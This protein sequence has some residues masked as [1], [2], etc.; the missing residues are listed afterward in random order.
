MATVRVGVGGW[1][2]APWR[3]NFYPAGLPHS[4]ELHH[5]S[6]RLT[7][8]EINGT[9]YSAQKPS[10]FAK[11]RDDTPENFVFSVK[12]SQYATHRRVLAEAGESVQRFVGGGVAELGP[13]LGP[14]VWQFM[15]TKQFDPVDFGAF[16]D[17]LPKTVAGLRLRHVVDV[18]HESFKTPAFI[19]LLRRHGVAAVLTDEP[20]LPSFANPTADFVY[21]RL[22][23]SR[24]E[25]SQGYAPA[26]LAA[27][28]ACARCWAVGGEPAGL[29]L[30]AEPDTAAAASGPRDV[31]VYFISGAKEKN[32]AAAQA[33]LSHLG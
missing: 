26:E 15:R 28:A 2:F 20:G 31:F 7:A 13:K 22:M 3:N 19:A 8:I 18:R 23:N 30:V 1:T 9:F 5:A 33:L 14:I 27:V 29:P 6:R 4:Q 16:L 24:A 25:L 11:W 17:L 12:A 32:P 10:T 21:L